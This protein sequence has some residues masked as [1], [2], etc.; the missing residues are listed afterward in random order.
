MNDGTPMGGYSTISPHGCSADR[1][2]HQNK[3]QQQ[4]HTINDYQGKL[5]D[6]VI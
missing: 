5:I 3:Q 6:V 1:P 2:H 4:Q